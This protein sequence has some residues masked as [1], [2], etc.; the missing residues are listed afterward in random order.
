ML[1]VYSLL[2]IGGGSLVFIEIDDLENAFQLAWS[3]I[4]V[5]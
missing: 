1:A 2:S 3:I 4:I 5:E